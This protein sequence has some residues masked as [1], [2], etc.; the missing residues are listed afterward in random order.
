MDRLG[1]GALY[2][3]T[4]ANF[5][6]YTDGADNRVDH[7]SP[8]GV[9][10]LV[11]TP[12][13]EYV[14]TDNVEAGRMRE[15]GTP[16]IEVVEHPWNADP[17]VA[18]RQLIGG[19]ALGVDLPFGGAR[20]V[21]S[22]VA[23]LRYVLDREATE[24]YRKVGADAA[25][26]MDEAAGALEPA[27]REGEA[28]AVL[29]AA[30][31]R[32][33]LFSPVLLAAS[34]RRMGLYRHPIPSGEPL[35]GR[36]MLVACAERGGL[37]ANL[38]RIVS[39]EE[40]DEDLALRQGATEGILRRMREEATRP[41]RTLADAFADCRSFYA[42]AGF[43]HEWRGHHQG[44]LTGYASREVVATAETRLE[45]Q[46]GMAFAW[47][48]SLPGAKAEETFVLGPDGPEIICT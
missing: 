30:L 19:A 14:L 25:A 20:D 4:P 17:T 42:E 44:G 11:L 47:N 13:D 33:G 32:R 21:A 36:A 37:Y 9:A 24:R 34:G 7:S 48:P 1:L 15:E 40:P 43:P 12:G 22:E 2:L 45:I 38:T 41:G 29:S 18:L 35:G 3:R 39:F 46:S 26:A 6:W 28:A 10:G 27:M 31:R 5:A 23:P 16:G 8:A